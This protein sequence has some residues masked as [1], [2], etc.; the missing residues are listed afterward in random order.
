MDNNMLICC[1][2]M[3]GT[4]VAREGIEEEKASTE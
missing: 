4:E 2:T 1:G 3:N